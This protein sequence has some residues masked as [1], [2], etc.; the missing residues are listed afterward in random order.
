MPWPIEMTE[1]TDKTGIA[2]RADVKLVKRFAV[3]VL[4]ESTQSIIRM[5][6]SFAVLFLRERRFFLAE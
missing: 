1:M 3:F 6:Q 5:L 4:T 2:V